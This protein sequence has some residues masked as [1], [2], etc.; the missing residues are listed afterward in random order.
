MT[1]LSLIVLLFLVSVNFSSVQLQTNN[2][3]PTSKMT[4][5]KKVPNCPWYFIFGI[6]V[7]LCLYLHSPSAIIFS[8][9]KLFVL[10]FFYIW[11]FCMCL[12]QNNWDCVMVSLISFPTW[13]NENVTILSVLKIVPILYHASLHTQMPSLTYSSSQQRQIDP[14]RERLSPFLQSHLR[15]KG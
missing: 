14:S 12:Q 11:W 15:Q 5:D 2:I 9:V 7:M 13:F 6:L 8:P 3:Y 4:V 1:F 10:A